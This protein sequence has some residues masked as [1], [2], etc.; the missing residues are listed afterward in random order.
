M[1]WTPVYFIVLM[2]IWHNYFYLTNCTNNLCSVD[3]SVSDNRNINGPS[4]NIFDKNFNLSFYNSSR[5]RYEFRIYQ[6]INLLV[7]KGSSN[8][9]NM[10][11]L[12]FFFKLMLSFNFLRKRKNDPHLWTINANIVFLVCI[13]YRFSK[14]QTC[15]TCHFFTSYF[16]RELSNFAISKSRL[17]NDNLLYHLLLLLLNPG[18][19]S[20]PQLLRVTVV[21]TRRVASC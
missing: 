9:E 10:N 6:K 19:F 12:S 1:A 3:V 16:E 5:L 11:I 17:K 2:L 14:S 13:L 7:P 15:F 21:Q 8:S 4:I 18:P 20:N